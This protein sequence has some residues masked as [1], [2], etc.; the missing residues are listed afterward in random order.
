MQHFNIVSERA[1]FQHQKKLDIQC[2]WLS[3]VTIIKNNTTTTTTTTT[4][5]RLIVKISDH[6]LILLLCVIQEISSSFLVLLILKTV[7]KIKA[8]RPLTCDTLN[9]PSLLTNRQF[10]WTPSRLLI[11]TCS[12]PLVQMGERKQFSLFDLDL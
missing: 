10:Q 3:V 8:D 7:L 12:A 1:A 5:L 9:A 2:I 11:L 6:L 4:V